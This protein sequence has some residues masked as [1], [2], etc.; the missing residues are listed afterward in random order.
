MSYQNTATTT[1]GVCCEIE[2]ER[3]R[4]NAKWASKE[5]VEM[6]FAKDFATHYPHDK[7]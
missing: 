6:H 5:A 7:E 2:A 1:F 3:E 4:Q